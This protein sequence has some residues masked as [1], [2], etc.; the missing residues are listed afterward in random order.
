MSEQT[1]KNM[2]YSRRTFGDD[3][4]VTLS[5]GACNTKSTF[6]IYSLTHGEGV[7]PSRA[8]AT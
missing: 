6:A 8:C 7:A 1:A 3:S 4:C 5:F 2:R